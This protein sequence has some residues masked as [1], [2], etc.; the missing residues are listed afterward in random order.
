VHAQ[1]SDYDSAIA[2]YDQAVKLDPNDAAAYINRGKVY[3]EKGDYDCGMTDLKK[4][5][6]ITS[7]RAVA[8]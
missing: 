1:H 8:R 5:L 7:D 3:F 2:D 4:A 6:K